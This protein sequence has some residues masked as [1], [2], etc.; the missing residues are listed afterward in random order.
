MLVPALLLPKVLTIAEQAAAVILQHYEAGTTISVKGDS[1]P[2]TEADEAGEAVILAALRLLTPD[3]PIVAEEAVARGELPDVG[4][5]PFWLVDP[6]DGTKE[7]ISRNGEFT[8][9]IGLIEHREPIL[10]VVL[11]PAR[12]LAWWGAEGL[13]ASR[14]EADAVRPI[15]VR[16]RAGEGAV[17]VASRSHRDAETDAWLKAE[18][19]EETVSAGSSLKFCL[20]AEGR[21]DVY[22]R[23]GP[24]M[25]WDT[26]AGDAV[27]RAAGGRVTTVEGD[28]FLYVKRGFR[29]PGFIAWGA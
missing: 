21:A 18:G 13:G 7:F 25:E 29:N 11:A 24:T 14:R 9:N 28:P 19:I 10:G 20:V 22:P 16:V 5:G 3:V 4:D 23:F 17:A 12:G 2:V 26:A 8:V 6:L 1:S 27:L 15:R